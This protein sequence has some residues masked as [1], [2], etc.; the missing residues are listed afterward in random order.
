MTQL[1]RISVEAVGKEKQAARVG[2]IGEL[3][4]KLCARLAPALGIA[5]HPARLG[6]EIACQQT[7]HYRVRMQTIACQTNRTAEP[8]HRR[9]AKQT[10]HTADHLARLV[11]V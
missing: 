10:G 1:V 9:I 11:L 2:L 6:L 3:L 8:N 5:G 4:R 7:D